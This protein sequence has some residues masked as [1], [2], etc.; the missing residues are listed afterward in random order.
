MSLET[1]VAGLVTATN[2]LT[3]TVNEKI[4]DIDSAKNAAVA[5][6][7]AR[8]ATFN[9][10][11]LPAMQAQTDAAETASL[12][13]HNFVGYQGLYDTKFPLYSNT[14]FVE[15]NELHFGITNI[16]VTD[17]GQINIGAVSSNPDIEAYRTQIL[18]SVPISY[19]H[20]AH[21]QMPVARVSWDTTAYTGGHLT[22]LDNAYGRPIFQ[23]P[24]TEA[25]WIRN[26]SG[27]SYSI[28]YGW[29]VKYQHP[30]AKNADGSYNYS[31]WHLVGF[32]VSERPS[33]TT[34]SV[35][36][37][38]PDCIGEFEMCGY[39]RSPGHA[40]LNAGKWFPYKKL[41]YANISF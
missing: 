6:M 27:K 2:N 21:E 38:A 7:D 16:T 32:H 31:N 28:N 30:S 18:H 40:D 35:P 5:T 25:V 20:Y 11:E 9:S 37:G 13:A 15:M 34:I 1:Q 22:R 3:G 8:V 33:H 14:N 26:V 36:H 19:H 17:L 23:G 29:K 41:T 39:S 10:T 12:S 4:A 24:H